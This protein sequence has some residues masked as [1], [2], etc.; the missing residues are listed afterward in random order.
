MQYLSLICG[1]AEEESSWKCKHSSKVQVPEN[2]TC[3][4]CCWCIVCYGSSPCPVLCLMKTITLRAQQLSQAPYLFQVSRFHRYK[5]LSGQHNKSRRDKV[6]MPWDCKSPS[7]LLSNARVWLLDRNNVSSINRFLLC[8]GSQDICTS[9]TINIYTDR[10]LIKSREETHQT[11]RTC[12]HLA[13]I[14]KT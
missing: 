7:V 3:Y 10:V 2:C 11:S 5:N 4:H 9:V 8:P 14:M 13:L 12:W 1:G 6:N